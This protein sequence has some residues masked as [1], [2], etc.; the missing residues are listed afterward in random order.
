[1]IC[2]HIWLFKKSIP[3]LQNNVQH[4]EFPYF[5]MGSQN[6]NPNPNPKLFSLLLLLLRFLRSARNLISTIAAAT[7]AVLE[8]AEVRNRVDE[9]P[10]RRRA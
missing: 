6:P 2:F 9:V 5:V 1:M 3:T 7:S 10:M 4:V 8:T